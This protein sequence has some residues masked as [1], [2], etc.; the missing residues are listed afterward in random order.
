MLRGPAYDG[1]DRDSPFFAGIGIEIF[2]INWVTAL[3]EHIP[4]AVLSR[5]SSYDALGSFVFIPL[6][7][8]IAGP[9]ADRFGVTNTLWGFLAIGLLSI[10]GALLS[11]DV[12]ELRRVE[13]AG[14]TE[15]E[16]RATAAS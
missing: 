15:A 9:L 8:V 12:R 7:L 10:G 3:H 13:P 1:G 6:G 14:Y 2:S 16:A 11:R 4:P 5:V